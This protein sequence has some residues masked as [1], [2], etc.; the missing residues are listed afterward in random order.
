[1]KKVE[2]YIC[3]ICGAEYKDKNVCTECEKNIANLYLLK[4]QDISQLKIIKRDTR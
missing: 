2:H 3:E 1:M 4:M